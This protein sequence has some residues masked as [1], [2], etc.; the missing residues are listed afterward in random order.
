M[1]LMGFIGHESNTAKAVNESE[2]VN[3]KYVEI[4]EFIYNHGEL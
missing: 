2:S 1:L 4:W 3:N